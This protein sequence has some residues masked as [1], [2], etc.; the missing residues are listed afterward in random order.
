MQTATMSILDI[1]I[2]IVVAV[3]YLVIVMLIK[4][5]CCS[6]SHKKPKNFGQIV[7]SICLLGV[8]VWLWEEER[9][10]LGASDGIVKVLKFL[11]EAF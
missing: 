7:I 5:G 9:L 10:S 4:L 3:W 11:S 1:L 6:G 8:R 2:A